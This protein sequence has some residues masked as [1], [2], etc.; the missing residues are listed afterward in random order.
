MPKYDNHIIHNKKEK[1]RIS[2]E[3]PERVGNGDKRSSWAG[4]LSEPQRAASVWGWGC[5]GFELLLI[6]SW[7]L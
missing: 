6:P 7:P 4:W 5:L 3:R 2:K 1:T